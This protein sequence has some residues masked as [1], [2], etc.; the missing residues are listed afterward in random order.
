VLSETEQDLEIIDRH[1]RRFSFKLALRS[2]PSSR[3]T[4]SL[5][6]T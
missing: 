3:L 2:L 1:P 4:S 5:P 6:L